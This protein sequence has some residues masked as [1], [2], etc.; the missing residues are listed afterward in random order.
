M[1]IF[2]SQVE[3]QSRFSQQVS[4]HQLEELLDL[5]YTQF[6]RSSITDDSLQFCSFYDA[7]AY[8]LARLWLK[9]ISCS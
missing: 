5:N 7:S 3:G 4:Q 9:Y 8:V 6:T 1:A 2:C